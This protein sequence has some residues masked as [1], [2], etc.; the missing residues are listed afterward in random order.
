MAIVMVALCLWVTIE[1]MAFWDKGIFLCSQSGTS[2][3]NYRGCP[4]SNLIEAFGTLVATAFLR[5]KSG[6]IL[7]HNSTVI[8][9]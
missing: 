8:Q 3:N 7:S 4:L 9:L 2:G 5:Y 1:V 6:I